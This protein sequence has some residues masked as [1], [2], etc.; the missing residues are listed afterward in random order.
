MADINFNTTNF[1]QTSTTILN[2]S[3]VD[4]SMN[5]S[6]YINNPW[7]FDI[8]NYTF[9][10]TAGGSKDAYRDCKDKSIKSQSDFFLVSDISYHNNQF[11]YNCYIP[12]DSQTCNINTLDKLI[13]PFK[14]VLMDIFDVNETTFDGSSDASSILNNSS[15][16]KE[17]PVTISDENFIHIDKSVHGCFITNKDILLPKKNFF[18]IFYNDFLDV[19]YD[20]QNNKTLTQEINTRINTIETT[21]TLDNLKNHINNLKSNLITSICD[22][23]SP[24][25]NSMDA[26]IIHIQKFYNNYIDEIIILSEDISNITIT[27]KNNVKY[28]RKVDDLVKKSEINLKKMLNLDGA[29][30]GKFNDT[31]YMKNHTLNQII[32]LILLIIFLIFIY[33]KKK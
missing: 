10:T 20:L 19:D 2:D 6:D 9:E 1:C 29:N 13:L 22:N 15:I 31:I 14:K 5:Y 25:I 28:L 27:S 11:N 21:Y 32:I 17:N 30:N 7:F 3:L 23:I 18:G 8:S 24:N 33:T 4:N 12:K 16:T 26:D